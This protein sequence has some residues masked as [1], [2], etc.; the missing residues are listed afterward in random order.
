MLPLL[1]DAR[2]TLRRLIREPA[3]AA[4]SVIAF[5]LGI[6]LTASMYSIAYTVLF[7][8]LPV[9]DPDALDFL[10]RT[11]QESGGYSRTVPFL[12]YL[13]WR[14]RQTGFEDLGA[15]AR[16]RRNL[17]DDAERPERV[18]GA[19]IT[20]NLFPT[21]GIAPALGR[22]LE[23][24]EIGPGHPV[25][26]ISDQLWRRRYGGDPRVLG[27]VI[28]A[29]G[30][31]HTIIGVMPPFFDFPSGQDLWFP[32]PWDP[33]SLRR[34]QEPVWVVGRLRLGTRSATVEAEMTSIAASLAREHPDTNRPASVH[35]E[36]LSNMFVGSDE[37]TILG[38]MLASSFFVLLIACANVANVLIARATA[39]SKQLA[40]AT[41]LGAS[42]S[43]LLGGL[44]LEA[45]ILAVTGGLLGV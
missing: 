13:D 15:Y 41:A 28:R 33:A 1:R 16:T 25:A 14:E 19:Y 17:A 5:A 8:G 31:P 3:L 42:R 40:I 12:D 4:I 36:P 39:R 24:D 45:A 7:R 44:L 30:E 20:P 35:A 10:S 29:D 38:A 26:I 34:D 23:D 11:D 2:L 18:E 9:R 22:G 6:G 27:Q 32:V 21:L 37:R 43:R